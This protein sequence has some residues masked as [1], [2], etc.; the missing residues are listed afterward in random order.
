MLSS[1]VQVIYYYRDTF[2]R[3][4]NIKFM[5]YLRHLTYLRKEWVKIK[6]KN[7]EKAVLT[8]YVPTTWPSRFMTYTFNLHTSSN[9]VNNVVKFSTSGEIWHSI[10]IFC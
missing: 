1:K 7:K 6:F 9:S 3:V 10:E 4:I 2:T 8:F 5:K